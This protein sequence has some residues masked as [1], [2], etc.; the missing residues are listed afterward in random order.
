M[1]DQEIKLFYLIKQ[2][3]NVETRQVAQFHYQISLLL[4]DN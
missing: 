2:T 4:P 3:K 1:K